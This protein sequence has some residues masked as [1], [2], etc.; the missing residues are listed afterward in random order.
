[1]SPE[2]KAYFEELIIKTNQSGK[3][4]TSGL[5]T[6]IMN[7]IKPLIKEAVDEA[8]D[9]SIEKNVNGKIRGLTSE[10]REYVIQDTDDKKKIFDWQANVTPSIEIMKRVKN[11]SDG[12][13]WIAKGVILIGAVGTTIYGLYKFLTLR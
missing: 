1:M 2:D 9:P 3:K 5:V 12:M 6:D 10:F 13:F 7:R 8:V 4:E 11:T